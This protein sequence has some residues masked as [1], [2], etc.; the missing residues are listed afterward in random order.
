[1]KE[2]LNSLIK[3]FENSPQGFSARKLSAFVLMTCVVYLH[4]R[5]VNTTVVV[6]IVLIDLCFVLLLL[7]I[8]TVQN[9]IDLRRK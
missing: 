4:Y 5:Y 1:M 2:L 6:D 9:I 7:G 8:I 3:S